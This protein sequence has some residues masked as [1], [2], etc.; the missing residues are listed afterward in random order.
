M[1][2][3]TPLPILEPPEI[4]TERVG[5]RE[6]TLLQDLTAFA[7]TEVVRPAPLPKQLALLTSHQQ[8]YLFADG[9]GARRVP[10]QNEEGLRLSCRLKVAM[11]LSRW[12]SR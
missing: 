8:I 3:D 9:F 4:C 11:R 1:Q 5:L 7:V 6:F 10:I 2:L 12:T